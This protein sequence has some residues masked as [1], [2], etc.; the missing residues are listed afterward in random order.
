MNESKTV[1]MKKDIFSGITA[2]IVA[3]PLALAFGIQSGLGAMAGL[4]G[5]IILGFF[6]ALLGGTR[7]QISGPT[8]PVAVLV[9]SF[10][11]V[12]TQTYSDPSQAMAVIVL[13]FI[14]V[15]LLQ[16]IMG[17]IKIGDLI[18]YIPYPVVSGFMSGVGF[19]VLSL[20]IFPALGHSSP[21]TINN[22]F[23][24]INEPLQ[25]INI[26][27]LLLSLLTILVIYVFPKITRIVPSSLVALLVLST[28]SQ[29]LELPVPVIGD[30][31][32]GIPM[33]QLQFLSYFDFSMFIHALTMACSI[34]ALCA[35][36]SL[37]TSVIADKLTKTL[38][39]GNRELIGQGIGNALCGLFGGLPGAGAT[40]RTVVN[41]RSGGR[42][43]LS[44]ITHSLVLLIIMFGL[45]PYA[46]KIP[47]AVLAGILITVGF[48]IIDHKSL[49][50][51]RRLPKTDAGVMILV[52]ILTM[53]VSLIHAVVIGIV[54]ASMMFMQKMSNAN[55]EG[56]KL[57][58][59]IT[60]GDKQPWQDEAIIPNTLH[61]K[62]YI[63]HLHGPLFFGFASHF[64]GLAQ[65]IPDIKTVIVRM[66]MVP[67]VDQSG[68]YAIE[69][70]YNMLSEKGVEVLFTG[71]QQQPLD[72]LHN[73][74]I[75][76][77][78]IPSNAIFTEFSEAIDYLANKFGDSH[79]PVSS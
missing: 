33:P 60:T 72:I 43:R 22:V 19:I 32:K 73:L 42:G 17:I 78:D 50:D 16:I 3:L 12:I 40:M 4:Y 71:F 39:D 58:P 41:I 26:H 30:I 62:V 24:H 21:A 66:K 48:S 52:I 70:V 69:E 6:A 7:S 23:L 63:K 64:Q 20:Q 46:A 54:V 13:T 55:I 61:D 68:I 53:F 47:L 65:K 67:F 29:V 14:L 11:A 56:S 31:P 18:C 74:K 8:G 10:I 25:A 1:L 15:G 27:A 28:I 76:P 51:V 49:K 77:E 36:D 59:L 5:A 45:G 9:A 57:M 35:I 44:G 79:V 75:I 34:A 2:A 38:H 37:L